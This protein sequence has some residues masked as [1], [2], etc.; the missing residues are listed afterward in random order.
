MLS[1]SV[2]GK[3]QKKNFLEKVIANL[4]YT[5]KYVDEFAIGTIVSDNLWDL[6]EDV[7]LG[8]F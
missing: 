1:N 4:I 6:A 8:L 7:V 2:S 5:P 3:Y